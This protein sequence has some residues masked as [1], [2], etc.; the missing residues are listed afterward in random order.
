MI[1]PLPAAQVWLSL[2]G[3]AARVALVI[4][5]QGTLP[6]SRVGEASMEGKRHVSYRKERREGGWVSRQ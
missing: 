5:A 4:T 3:L 6:N 2:G 1:M